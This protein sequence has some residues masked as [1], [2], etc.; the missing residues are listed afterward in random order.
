MQ[1]FLWL[2]QADENVGSPLQNGKKKKSD[3]GLNSTAVEEKIEYSWL[4]EKG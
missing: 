3:R 1:Y 2:N 4:P